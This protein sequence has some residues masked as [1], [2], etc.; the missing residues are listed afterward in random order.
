[1]KSA[2]THFISRKR[3]SRSKTIA[4]KNARFVDVDH[5][6]FFKP[7]VC[8]MIRDGSILAMPGLP[9]EAVDII[10]DATVDMQGK[11]VMPGLFN[12]H[13]HIQMINPTLFSSFKT[14]KDR[15]RHHDAQVEKNMAD[16]LAQG[17]TNI[18]DAY[19][20][21][22]RPNRLLNDRINRGEIPGPRI[23][24]AVVV[25]ALGG[26]LS[27][28]PR[29][30]KKKLLTLMGL[31]DFNYE[32]GHSGVVAF[33]VDAGEQTVRD[34]V[35][36]AVEERGADLI[37]VGESLEESLL[38]SDPL[39]MTT[40]QLHAITSQAASL[41]LQSTIHSVSLDTFRRAVAAGFSSLAHMARNGDL[42]PEDVET[43]LKADTVIEPTLSVGFDMSWKLQGNEYAEDPNMEAMTQFREAS[44][45][46]LAAA[47][48]LPELQ[49]HVLDGFRKADRGR[50]KMIGLLDLSKLLRH[51][52]P[53]IHFGMNNTRQLLASGVPMAC[54]NDGGIQSCTP[55]M[56]AHELDIFDRFM[57]T[58][59]RPLF[60][61]ATA[62][63]T[64]TINSA[65]S[66]GIDDQFGSIQTGKTADL[67]VVDGDPFEDHRVIGK[68][69]EA[70]FM[71]GELRIDNCGLDRDKIWSGH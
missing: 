56:I 11:T 4:L 6:C 13:C 58:D 35:K 54:G 69:V 63:R 71:D 14:I 70:L 68:R 5:G 50:Y 61:P 32:I 24:Q 53:L 1:M 30:L 22:L 23:Q 57:N 37:K 10:P 20:D 25:G 41:N 55:A 33:P 36:R 8:V 12:V 64:A 19:T 7:E 18:R 3:S 39:I 40:S 60:D 44:R 67:V 51:F 28:D 29:G 65:R 31:G 52:C 48:W 17:V 43:C 59:N 2:A 66:M 38:N 27:P 47:F 45:D 49:N 21:D 34:S 9:G 16:C 46:H 15:K 26:Y 62:L 42:S